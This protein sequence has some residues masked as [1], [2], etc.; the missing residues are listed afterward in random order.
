MAEDELTVDK[1]DTVKIYKDDAHHYLK[2][3]KDGRI[4]NVPRNCI[5]VMDEIVSNKKDH[6]LL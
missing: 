2:C 6:Y 5:K 4:G 1:D 3:E